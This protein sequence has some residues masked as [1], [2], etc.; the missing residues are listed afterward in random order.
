[1]LKNLRKCKGDAPD[2]IICII[3]HCVHDIEQDARN[4]QRLNLLIPRLFDVRLASWMLSPHSTEEDLEFEK[5]QAGFPHLWPK[6]KPPPPN[7]SEQMVG[8]IEAKEN[9]QFLYALYPIV[10]N[11]LDA[12]GLKNAFEDIESP[13]QSILSSMECNGIA[14]EIK[15]L[16]IVN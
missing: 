8:L 13:V 2:I 12:N 15:C 4:E 14:F 9:L 3:Y 6:N 7:A 5:K 10:Q 11:L 16:W 1:M